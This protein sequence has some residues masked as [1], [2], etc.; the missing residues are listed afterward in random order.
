M[1]KEGKEWNGCESFLLQLKFINSSL[2][3]RYVIHAHN[4]SMFMSYDNPS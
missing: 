2:G 3:D 1:P 4:R